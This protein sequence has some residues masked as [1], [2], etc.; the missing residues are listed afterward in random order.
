M[1]S[2]VPVSLLSELSEINEA[3]TAPASASLDQ[4]GTS[5]NNDDGNAEAPAAGLE[6]DAM[7]TDDSSAEADEEISWASSPIRALPTK[8]ALQLPPDSSDPALNLP[9][10]GTQRSSQRHVPSSPPSEEPESDDS[11]VGVTT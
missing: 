11:M 4:L 9:R 8:P 3:D 6:S 1:Q 7:D 2:N 10:S 5:T